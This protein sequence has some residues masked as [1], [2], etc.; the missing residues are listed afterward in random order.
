MRGYCTPKRIRCSSLWP[1]SRVSLVALTNY[2]LNEHEHL[3]EVWSISAPMLHRR[4]QG[5]VTAAPDDREGYGDDLE[6]PCFRCLQ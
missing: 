1:L 3:Y 4:E 6:L 5:M 2:S